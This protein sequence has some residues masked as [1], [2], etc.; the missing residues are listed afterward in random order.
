MLIEREADLP[1]TNTTQYNY[2][3]GLS[4]SSNFD[5]INRKNQINK[6]NMKLLVQ[7]ICCNPKRM[8]L[9]KSN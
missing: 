1:L 8:K 2:G 6:L 4:V 9:D 5:L 7:K 3:V